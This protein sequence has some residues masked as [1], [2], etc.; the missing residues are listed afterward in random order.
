MQIINGLERGGD[1]GDIDELSSP[2]YALSRPARNF[3]GLLSPG[4]SQR[5]RDL[6]F[7]EMEKF[8]AAVSAA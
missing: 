7:G 1:A 3:A 8:L 4:W 6:A 5:G 2:F